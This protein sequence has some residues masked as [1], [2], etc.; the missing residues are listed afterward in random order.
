MRKRLLNRSLLS[1]LQS[2]VPQVIMAVLVAALVVAPAAAQNPA[3]STRDNNAARFLSKATFGADMTLIRQVARTGHENWMEQ[4]FETNPTLHQP[5]TRAV[6]L[7]I[8]GQVEEQIDRFA[9]DDMSEDE[10]IV[11]EERVFDTYADLVF[12]SRRFAWWQAAMTNNDPLR[13]RVA[14]ALSQI[15]V[16]SDLQD[17]LADN[18]EGLASYY[19]VLVRNSFGNYRNLLR[20]VT[21]HPVMGVYLSHFN[22]AKA[23]PATGRFPDENYAREVMQLFSIG[24]Y[25]LKSNGQRKLD[26]DGRPIATYTNR[27]ITEF[28]KIFTGLGTG[29]PAWAVEEGAEDE[30][31]FGGEPDFTVPMRMYGEHHSRGKKT[32]L[33]GQVVPAGQTAMQDLDAAIDNLFN[34][35]NVGPFIGRQLIQRLVTSNPSPA[36]IGRVSKAFANNGAGVRGDMKAVLKA[37]LLDPEAQRIAISQRDNFGHLQEPLLRIV[38]LMRAF[39]ARSPIGYYPEPGYRFQESLLQHPLSS[40]SVFN[41][42]SPNHQPKGP[43]SDRNMVAPE[44]QINTSA[45]VVNMANLLEGMLRYDEVMELPYFG[46]VCLM[47]PEMCDSIFNCRDETCVDEEIERIFDNEDEIYPVIQPFVV[48]FDLRAETGL[49]VDDVPGLINRIDLLVSQGRMSSGT[50]AILRDAVSQLEEPEE[51]VRLALY[52]AVLSPHAAVAN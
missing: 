4:Q 48:R 38:S 16:V 33:R 1:P 49:A 21:L 44:F 26:A 52:L 5:F 46:L 35:P 24:L 43:I 30:Y 3:F 37:V 7:L 8:E 19:D 28:A 42:F 15:F 40:P 51:R 2:G 11:L 32:L 39:N 6:T 13:Q 45:T 14:F 36:Y 47:R 18:P 12:P 23:D 34:H 29:V 10:L 27:E 20:E 41:F 9:D 25:E 22:N 50:R 31:F 17:E